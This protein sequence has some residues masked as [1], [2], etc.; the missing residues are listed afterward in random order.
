M[1]EGCAMGTGALKRR[2]PT[3]GSANGIPSQRSVPLA[4]DPSPAKLPEVRRTTRLDVVLLESTASAR[5][6]G[7]AVPYAARRRVT[8]KTL[9]MPMVIAHG[10]VDAANLRLIYHYTTQPKAVHLHEK[11]L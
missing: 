10:T 7:E 3:G 4:I 9:V 2:L 5:I 6:T 1:L 8:K 11:T